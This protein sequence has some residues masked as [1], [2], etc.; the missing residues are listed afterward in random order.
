MFIEYYFS[1]L[2]CHWIYLEFSLERALCKTEYIIF[3]IVCSLELR[4]KEVNQDHQIGRKE[5]LSLSNWKHNFNNMS[6]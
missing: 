2:L 4:V 1:S 6:L 5:P 3:F